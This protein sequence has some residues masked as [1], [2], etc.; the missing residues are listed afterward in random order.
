MWI[1]PERRRLHQWFVPALAVSVGVAIGITMFARGDT[2]TGLVTLAVL[3]GYGA[4]LAYRRGETAFAVHE[5]FG[6]GRRSSVHIRAAAI[7]GDMIVGLIVAAL[8]VQALRGAEIGVL[9]GLAAIAGVTYF[10]S[11]VILNHTY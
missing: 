1:A 9:A 8:L 2:R 7:T 6:G 3:V 11:I 4:M 5:A 10:I